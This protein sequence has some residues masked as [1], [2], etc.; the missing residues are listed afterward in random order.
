[1]IWSFRRGMRSSIIWDVTQRRLVDSY[2]R[3]ET[4]FRPQSQWWSS[5]SRQPATLRYTVCRDGVGSD[6]GLAQNVTLVSSVS[7]ACGLRKGEGQEGIRVACGFPWGKAPPVQQ[8]TFR[9][10]LDPFRWYL[11][12]S[13]ISV[14]NDEST[15]HDI[16]EDRRPHIQGVPGGMCNISGECSLC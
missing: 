7:S 3:F 4:I 2:R 9:G 11:C 14:T 8:G 10:L 15:L 6:D 13:E 16:T 5:P 1:M 12:F